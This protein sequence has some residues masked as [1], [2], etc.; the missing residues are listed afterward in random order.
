MT[1]MSHSQTESGVLSKPFTDLH[2]P[3]VIELTY[4]DLLTKYEHS[5]GSVSFTLTK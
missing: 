2:D 4:N 5:Y 3:R 1:R